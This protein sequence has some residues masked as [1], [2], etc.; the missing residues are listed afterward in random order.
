MGASARCR[1]FGALTVSRQFSGEPLTN[2]LPVFGETR[3]LWIGG[4][5]FPL[6]F[7]MMVR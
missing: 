4:S 6:S 7:V 5:G 3:L 1:A 2:L